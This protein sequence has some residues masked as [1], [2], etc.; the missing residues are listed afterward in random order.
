MGAG[1]IKRLETVEEDGVKTLRRRADQTTPRAKALPR[2]LWRLER[3]VLDRRVF[4]PCEVRRRRAA[5]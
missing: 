1:V 2:G 4:I 3:N 5:F